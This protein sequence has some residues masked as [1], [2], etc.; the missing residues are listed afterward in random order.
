[1]T[2]LDLF[3]VAIF[4]EGIV[5]GKNAFDTICVFWFSLQIYAKFWQTK[6]GSGK[7]YQKSTEAFKWCAYPFYP[8]LTKLECSQ[9]VL[10]KYLKYKMSQKLVE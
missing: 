1:M 4:L 7:Y 8:I 6:K 9:R 3:F 5:F 10:G 2:C